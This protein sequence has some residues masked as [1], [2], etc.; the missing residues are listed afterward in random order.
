MVHV[1]FDGAGPGGHF[2][3]GLDLVHPIAYRLFPEEV[4]AFLNLYPRYFS[5]ELNVRQKHHDEDLP[6]IKFCGE[7]AWIPIQKGRYFLREQPVG[8]WADDIQPWTK[9]ASWPRTVKTNMDQC[10]TGAIDEFGSP[11]KKPTQWMTNHERLIAPL[12]M[13]RCDMNH[14]HCCPTNKSLEKLK[15]YPEK[16]CNVVVDGIEGLKEHLANNRE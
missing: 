2:S 14:D 8:N 4:P 7:V 12:R 11:A 15:Q 3:P 6:H 10:M 16:L 13:Y 9:V 5:T 1:G